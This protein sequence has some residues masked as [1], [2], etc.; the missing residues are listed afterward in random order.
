MCICIC[1]L[2]LP[3]YQYLINNKFCF[4]KPIPSIM[5]LLTCF[6][7]VAGNSQTMMIGGSAVTTL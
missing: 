4:V 3:I 6:I 2:F 1:I 5:V 7:I